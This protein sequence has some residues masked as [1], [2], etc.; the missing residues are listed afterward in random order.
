MAN[1]SLIFHGT[2]SS[3]TNKK[4]LEC[5]F[6]L[7]GGVTI[8]IKEEYEKYP[9]VICLDVSTAIK[10]YKVLRSEISTAKESEVNN[11]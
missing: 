1:I 7:D 10:L 11:D 3:M 9:S 4:Q 6:N 2:E 8:S 5:Y